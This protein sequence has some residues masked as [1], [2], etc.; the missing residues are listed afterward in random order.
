MSILVSINCIAYNHEKYIEKAI[1]SF[2]MQ[3]TDFEYE[4]IIHDDAS[5]DNTAE[6]IRVYELKYPYKIKGIYQKENQYS[7]GLNRIFL[8]FLQ[9]ASNGK[10]IAI[11]E[12]DDY[13]T[14]PYKLQKQ[15][16]VLESNSKY[17]MCIHATEII[18]ESGVSTGKIIRPRKKN[19]VLSCNDMILGGS[20]YH[21]NSL[22]YTKKN[23][24]GLPRWFYEAPGSHTSMPLI[25]ANHGDVYFIDE[26]MSSW[27]RGTLDGWT[28]REW[29]DIDRRKRVFNRLIEMLDGF[30]EF[31]NEKY[32][33]AVNQK[34]LQYQINILRLEKNLVSLI[35]HPTYNKYRQ[36]LSIVKQFKLV[37][38][39]IILAFYNSLLKHREGIKK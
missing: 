5:T 39:D 22:V 16:D 7:K 25:L 31:T 21:L 19:T 34:K 37:S 18:T 27:R 36:Y 35:F 12:A 23:M 4:I 9:P 13:W 6:I 11:C 33:N 3:K 29:R 14:D 15:I 24:V 17:S 8:N 28:M 10:Y 2:L 38:R 30:N 26:V 1:E 20:F 32:Q